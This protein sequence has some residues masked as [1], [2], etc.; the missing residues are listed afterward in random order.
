MCYCIHY[1]F[2][3]SFSLYKSSVFG[4]KDCHIKLATNTEGITFLVPYT[5]ISYLEAWHKR[6]STLY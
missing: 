4:G 2:R 1:I 6:I 3:L 5:K